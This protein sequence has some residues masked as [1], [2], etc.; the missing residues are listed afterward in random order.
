LDQV[1]LAVTFY[2]AYPE[3]IDAR[4]AADETAADHI[5]V[6]INR[7]DQLLSG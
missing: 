6:M 4:I 5:R 3:E 7:R 1:R 2:S